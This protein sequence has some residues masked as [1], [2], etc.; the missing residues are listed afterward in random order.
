MIWLALMHIA[1]A[2]DLPQCKSAS[3]CAAPGFPATES[4][5]VF[6]RI[7]LNGNVA[8]A[9]PA[10][11]GLYNNEYA[12]G[13]YSCSCC[14]QLLY[15]SA[16]KYAAGEGWPAFWSPLSDSAVELGAGA[17]NEISCRHCGAHLG[18]RFNDGPILKG[19]KRDC[20]DSACLHFAS[21]ASYGPGRPDIHGSLGFLSNL[22]HAPIVIAI[23]GVLLLCTAALL[24]VCGIVACRFRRERRRGAAVGEIAGVAA[25]IAFHSLAAGPAPVEEEEEGGLSDLESSWTRDE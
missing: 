24:G 5:N 16:T 4:I 18:H 12:A 15:S 1:T 19:G 23:I 8:A 3:N 25:G 17:V 2:C 20:I 13:V 11:S 9:E 14:G 22:L 7:C 10:Y 6:N 21:N